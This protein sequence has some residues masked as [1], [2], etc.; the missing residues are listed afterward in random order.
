MASA[1]ST[2]ITACGSTMLTNTCASGSCRAPGRHSTGPVRIET[3]PARKVSELKAEMLQVS[4]TMRGAAAARA[5]C[6][7]RPA[8][9]NRPSR[10]AGSAAS[11][12]RTRRR[13]SPASADE[14]MRRQAQAGQEQARRACASAMVTTVSQMVMQAPSQ[15]TRQVVPDDAPVEG[16]DEPRCASAAVERDRRRAPP[17]STAGNRRS[18]LRCRARTAG[19]SC[20]RRSGSGASSSGTAMT[21]AMALSL[22]AMTK[23]EPSAGSMRISACG[24]MMVRIA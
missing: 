16:H 3:M 8:A 11:R 6:R 17:D 22:M 12:G 20:R 5:G 23:S 14:P 21:E 9:R 24:R 18:S 15:K 13:P 2:R 10:S 19:R 4:P 1:G 7:N